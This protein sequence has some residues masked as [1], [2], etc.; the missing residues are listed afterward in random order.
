MNGPLQAS[1]NGRTKT[2]GYGSQTGRRWSASRLPRCGPAE[3]LDPQPG[4][5]ERAATPTRWTQWADGTVWWA[6]ARC[7]GHH[8]TGT[9]HLQSLMRLPADQSGL[10]QRP[11][12]HLHLTMAVATGGG[13]QVEAGMTSLR[14]RRRQ[15]ADHHQRAISYTWDDQWQPGGQRPGVPTPTMPPT[16]W[17]DLC[18]RSV[19]FS[20]D[21]LGNRLTQVPAGVPITYSGRY[22]RGSVPSAGRDDR[23]G[24]YD[25]SVRAEP[26]LAS[27]WPTPTTSARSS[28]WQSAML[29]RGY[30][31]GRAMSCTGASRHAPEAATTG[32]GGFRLV[33]PID[34]HNGATVTCA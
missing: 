14:L 33:R 23:H 16:G 5:V 17:M 13:R 10:Q 32:E 21:G 4:S 20:Y 28:V 31:R 6:A 8:D 30:D 11:R 2:V 24:G 22:C 27:T 3:D 1:R 34:L 15:P 29:V 26:A 12:V 7:A 18:E 25:L 19:A 9:G